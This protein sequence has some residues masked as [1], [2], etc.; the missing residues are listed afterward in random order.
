MKKTY[1]IVLTTIIIICSFIMGS[2]FYNLSKDRIYSDNIYDNVVKGYSSSN[3]SVA[4]TN[5]PRE[6]NIVYKPAE[7]W[8]YN[9]S[10]RESERW[11][12]HYDINSGNIFLNNNLTESFEEQ[13]L[14]HEYGHAFLYDY[15]V[16]ADKG[17]V[18][19]LK[20]IKGSI[21]FITFSDC[22][23]DGIV[24]SFLYDE[25]IEELI[26]EYRIQNS[27]VYCNLHY[28]S[29]FHEYF[30]ESY[31]RYLNGQDIPEK[32]FEFMESFSE[33]L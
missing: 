4:F 7:F 22:K 29:N 13:V 8:E 11:N 1:F 2:R 27:E 18:T 26:Q 24:L 5:I 14:R 17:E 31:R 20:D 32:M 33:E 16:E 30:A 25:T 10:L 3:Y 28:T 12:G 6:R 9:H 23:Q 15:M 19:I 21:A